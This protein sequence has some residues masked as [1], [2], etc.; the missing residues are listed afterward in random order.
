MIRQY[1][2]IF[3]Y[4]LTLKL[5]EKLSFYFKKEPFLPSSQILQKRYPKCFIKFIG[6]ILKPRSSVVL[7]QARQIPFCY[8]SFSITKQSWQLWKEKK[9]YIKKV[10]SSVD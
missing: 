4:L 2:C 10:T 1:G 7:Y 5:S 6:S 3:V 8:S 9:S